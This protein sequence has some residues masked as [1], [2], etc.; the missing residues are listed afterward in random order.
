MGGN[1]D[2][3]AQ[4]WGKNN[5]CKVLACN[6]LRIIVAKLPH[7]GYLGYVY[8]WAFFGTIGV[9]Y[10]NYCTTGLDNG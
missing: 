4:F 8:R 10:D 6:Y 3:Q 5:G 9:R 7:I 2:Y 1:L